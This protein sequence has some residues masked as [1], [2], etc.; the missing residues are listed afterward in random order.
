[1]KDRVR[2]VGVKMDSHSRLDEVRPHG[3]FRD[4]QFQ[5]SKRHA[6]V[7]ADLPL[8]LNAKDFVEID[9]R[10]GGEG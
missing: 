9:A 4:L 1:M 8:F 7:V 3:A 5:R 10:N 6:V 2:A